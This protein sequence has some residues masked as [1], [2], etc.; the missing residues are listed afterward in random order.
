[1]GETASL[2][3]PVRLRGATGWMAATSAGRVTL[4]RQIGLRGPSDSHGPRL[5]DMRQNAESRKM[6]SDAAWA[7]ILARF[8]HRALG[9]LRCLL[10]TSLERGRRGIEH[11]RAFSNS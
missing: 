2:V 6:P 8:H 4:S 7:L 5:H 1:M 3:L 10:L 9:I 11:K